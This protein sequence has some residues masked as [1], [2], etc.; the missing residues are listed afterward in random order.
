[1]TTIMQAKLRVLGGLVVAVAV[2]A[3]VLG[4]ARPALA[5]SPW[6]HLTSNAAPTW[7]Q[8]GRGQDEA[9]ELTVSATEG[10]F[11]LI[12]REA[13]ERGE[14]F[15][16][17]GEPEF[18][19]LNFEAS[20]EAVQAGLEG[21]FGAGNVEV[22]GGP[23]DEDGTKPY[24][25]AFTGALSDR[26]VE[27]LIA[28]A[29][30]G[31]NG[32]QGAGCKQEATIREVAV[33]RADGRLIVAAVNEGDAGVDATSA[34]VTVSDRLPAGVTAV[35]ITG[36]A[37]QPSS[38][39][40]QGPVSCSLA[41]VSCTYASRLAPYNEIKMFIAVKLDPGVQSGVLNEVAV[42]GGNATPASASRPIVVKAGATPYGVQSYE[43][44]PEEEG[45]GL[46][47]SAL[48]SSW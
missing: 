18:T 13:F 27:P 41:T 11:A 47:T 44:T 6:W 35:S 33:G 42:S 10:E 32:A 28:S 15:N 23:G 29:F 48:L 9:Q 21:V 34:P 31:C 25:I 17:K 2:A 45:G 8:S 38:F 30:L 37:G 46:A 40:D 43:V 16:S 7:L 1:M 19:V 20:A 5:A 4:G 24:R 12:D 26:R 3:V 22:T 36:Q 14:L 39:E